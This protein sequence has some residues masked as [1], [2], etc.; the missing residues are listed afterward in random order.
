VSVARGVRVTVSA[1]IHFRQ[2]DDEGILLDLANGEYYSLNAVA[3]RMWNALAEGKSP[4]EVARDL[5]PDY[6][7]DSEVLVQDCIDLVAA[8]VARRF[9][10]PRT[11]T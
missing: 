3:T 4:E 1:D 5:A 2:F 6:A 8:L 10:R 11:A 9:V 7:I